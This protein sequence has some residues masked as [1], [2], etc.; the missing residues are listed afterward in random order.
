L[1]K[2]SSLTI[3][4]FIFITRIKYRK[5]KLYLDRFKAVSLFWNFVHFFF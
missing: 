2:K 4:M 3:I 1:T 5:I